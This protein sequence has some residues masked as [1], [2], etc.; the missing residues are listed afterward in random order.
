MPVAAAELAKLFPLDALRPET[1]EQL[2]AEASITEY[3]RNETIFNA[4]DLDEDTVYI[5]DGE[6]KCTYP[7]GRVVQHVAG[8]GHGRY[9]LNDAVPRRF[10]ATVANSMVKALRLERRFVEKIIAWDQLSRDP[11]YLFHDNRAGANSWVFRLLH[12][13]AFI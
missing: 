9:A 5:L 10:T 3:R 7:D 11:S 13:H 6:V 4:G 8:S 12:I 1:R 2:G